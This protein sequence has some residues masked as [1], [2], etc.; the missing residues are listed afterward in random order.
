[1]NMPGQTTNKMLKLFQVDESKRGVGQLESNQFHMFSKWYTATDKM[2]QEL[3]STSDTLSTLV[4][5]LLGFHFLIKPGNSPAYTVPGL[6]AL[7]ARWNS[8]VRHLRKTFFFVKLI[9]LTTPNPRPHFTPNIDC[10]STQAPLYHKIK[11]IKKKQEKKSTKIKS[12]M[13]NGKHYSYY[14]SFFTK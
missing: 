12:Q 13:R 6:V 3:V 14:C 10:L 11:K 9:I 8:I 7:L 4:V 2:T 1:M 5:P